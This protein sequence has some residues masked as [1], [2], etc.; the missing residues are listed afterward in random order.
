MTTQDRLQSPAE[1]H[2]R[3]QHTYE[4]ILRHPATHD[5]EWHDVRSLLESLAEVTAGANDSLNATR[6]GYV[7][8]LH[9]PK[10]Q[11]LATVEDLLAVRQFL[12]QSGDASMPLPVVPGIHLLVVID[13]RE[14][15]IYRTEFHGT[16]PQQIA[17]YDPHG[18]GLHLRSHTEETDGM[19]RPEVNGFYDAVAATLRGADQILIFGSGTG[20]NSAM[21]HLLADL[22]Q[23]HR[24][25]AKLI[26]GSIVVDTHHLTDG[27]LLAQARKFFGST[28]V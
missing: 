2:G 20:E 28:G 19:R 11:G 24:D 27:Q 8:T 3:H 25:V 1:L 9:A 23:N 22:K 16:V 13:H 21:E 4:A 10:H 26:V 17:P 14:A 12:E 18:F 15:K 5:L 6:N 7:V